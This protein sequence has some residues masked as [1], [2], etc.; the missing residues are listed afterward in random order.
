MGRRPYIETEFTP[1]EHSLMVEKYNRLF[2]KHRSLVTMIV[3]KHIKYNKKDDV[4]DMIQNVWMKIW[5]YIDKIEEEGPYTKTYI[6][7]VA[8]NQ[9]W[10][11]NK[12]KKNSIFF[13]EGNISLSMDYDTQDEDEFIRFNIESKTGLM[14]NDS[15]D[16]LCFSQLESII[17]NH[18]NKN[19]IY[20]DIYELLLYG[21]TLKEIRDAIDYD[22]TPLHFA[23]IVKELKEN[24]REILIEYANDDNICEDERIRLKKNIERYETNEEADYGDN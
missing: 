17:N 16:A 12:N 22:K 1:E 6:S 8:M 24:I 21:Y 4:D 9:T 10:M 20:K 15:H 3:N 14:T 18:L 7:K 11:Y 23:L 19:K 5:R 2:K 13:G